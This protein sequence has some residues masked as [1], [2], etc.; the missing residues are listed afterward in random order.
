M[1]HQLPCFLKSIQRLWGTGGL[2]VHSW[3]CEWLCWPCW[4]GFYWE[5]L[6]GTPWKRKKNVVTQKE[7]LYLFLKREIPLSQHTHV[8]I[9][10]ISPEADSL[11][12]LLTVARPLQQRGI[13]GIHCPNKATVGDTGKWEKRAQT[14]DGVCQRPSRLYIIINHQALGI[15]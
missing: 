12:R 2:V 14:H 6:D 15:A 13:Q 1:N 5:F 4:M 9:S 3:L 10:W 8:F 11:F 7:F